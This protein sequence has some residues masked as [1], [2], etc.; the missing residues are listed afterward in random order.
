MSTASIA[1]L[2]LLVNMAK[3]SYKECILLTFNGYNHKITNK[4]L[5]L[6]ELDKF[7]LGVTDYM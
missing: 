3:E 7:S 6:E 2:G 1:R 5:P 4:H